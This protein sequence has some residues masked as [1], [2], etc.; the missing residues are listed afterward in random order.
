MITDDELDDWLKHIDRN[1]WEEV[2]ELLEEI[3]EHRASKL[4]PATKFVQRDMTYLL[5]K[6]DEE[7][8]EVLAEVNLMRNLKDYNKNILAMELVDVQTVCETILEHIGFSQAERDEVRRAVVGKNAARGY[9]EEPR[10]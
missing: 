2:A 8:E 5:K 10:K 4:R 7:H 3:K 6:L 1:R 9:Y